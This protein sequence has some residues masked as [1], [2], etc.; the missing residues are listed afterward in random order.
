MLPR[1]FKLR[2]TVRRWMC[3][4]CVERVRGGQFVG[5]A[6]VRPRR[7]RARALAFALLGAMLIVIEA[8]GSATSTRLLAF[9]VMR[10]L[11]G[12]RL[13]VLQPVVEEKPAWTKARQRW[14]QKVHVRNVP[15]A[16]GELAFHVH[17]GAV[18]TAVHGPAV[19]GEQ[20]DCGFAPNVPDVVQCVG[21][22]CDAMLLKQLPD[23][24]SP[25]RLTDG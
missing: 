11:D 13:G 12:R 1:R 18:P 15:P 25:R 3:A 5:G 4:V 9:A 14:L 24:R 2:L 7:L 8:V 6:L 17:G 21:G 22:Q 10:C 19:C 20:V 16:H 23:S